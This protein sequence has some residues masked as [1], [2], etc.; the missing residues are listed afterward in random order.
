MKVSIIIFPGS[1]CDKDVAKAILTITNTKPKMIWHKESN[2]SKS[3]LI[4]IPGGFSYGD[5]LRSGA[6]AAHS[7]IMKDI[8]KHAKIGTPILGICNGFQ[9]LTEANLLPG[10]LMLNTN[11]K[12]VCKSVKITNENSNSIFTKCYKNNKITTL[13]VANKLGNFQTDKDTLT[14]LINEDRIAFRYCDSKLNFS[15]NS[16]PNGSLY[17]IAGI[18]NESGRIL[19]MMPHPERTHYRLQEKYVFFSKLISSIN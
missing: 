16:N 5:Y 8:V 11:L 10:A 2:L 17:N 3:D 6:I 9:I 13:A 12:F 19:G 1:N 15:N 7:P 14:T 4:I 18:L